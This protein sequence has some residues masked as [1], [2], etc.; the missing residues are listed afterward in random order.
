MATQRRNVSKSK[1]KSFSKS[2]KVSSSRKSLIKSR[3]MRGGA[4]GVRLSRVK[5]KDRSGFGKTPSKSVAPVLRKTK[6]ASTLNSTTAFVSRMGIKNEPTTDFIKRMG[7]NQTES[8]PAFFS[9]M[10]LKNEPTTDFIKR[11]G[12]NQT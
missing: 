11:M 10:G 4:H 3:K 9:R 1:S 2:N 5:P 12:L 7:L 8:Q 6:A